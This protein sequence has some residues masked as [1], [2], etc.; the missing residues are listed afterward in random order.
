MKIELSRK[1][2]LPVFLTVLII[3]LIGV[4]TWL[5]LKVQSY[6]AEKTQLELRISEMEG[7]VQEQSSSLTAKDSEITQLNESKTSLAK[8]VETLE[9]QKP[10]RD[11]VQE[12][13]SALRRVDA[14][15]KVGSDMFNFNRLLGDAQA[16]VTEAAN[17]L[18]KGKLKS[19]LEVAVSNY[20]N[21]IGSLRSK[22]LERDEDIK[23][24]YQGQAYY[25]SVEASKN[26][27]IATN[28]AKTNS[29]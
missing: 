3:S 1:T 27:K 8:S 23:G 11:A 25:Y 28:L 18:P 16:K 24:V 14:A 21:A 12:A 22:I 7:Q 10:Q 19:N 17:L 6:S 29:Y 13:L 9:A 2:I 15:L 4:G 20:E 26:I 5:A